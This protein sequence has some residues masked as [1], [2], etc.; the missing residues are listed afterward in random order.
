MVFIVSFL[1]SVSVFYPLLFHNDLILV[2]LDT[3]FGRANKN[4]VYGRCCGPGD[5][6]EDSFSKFELI[7][8]L[9]VNN[10]KFCSQIVPRDKKSCR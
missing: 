1:Q 10:H 2:L 4:S 8:S 5:C 6:S 7:C 3:L 9:V